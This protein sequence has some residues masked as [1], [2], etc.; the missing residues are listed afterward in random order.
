MGADRELVRRHVAALLEE[1]GAAGIPADVVGRLL[2]SAAV[3]IWGR[4]RDW[5]D[6][7]R[8]L[9][10]TAEN[11]DPDTDHEFMRP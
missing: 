4:E 11:L 5:Q 1:A 6:I 8:E 3:E 10:Y 7:A 9:A 2:V